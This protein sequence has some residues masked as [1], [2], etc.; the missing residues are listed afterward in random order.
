MTDILRRLA[1]KMES[2]FQCAA[3]PH[4]GQRTY[5]VYGILKQL[6]F[7]VLKFKYGYG[8]VFL[9]TG[10][11]EKLGRK[12]LYSHDHGADKTSVTND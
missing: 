12:F 7:P 1:Q 11:S 5:G 8:T 4:S 3:F 10:F 2:E 6:P 9:F